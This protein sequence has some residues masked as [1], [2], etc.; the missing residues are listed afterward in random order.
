MIIFRFGL[1]D[2]TFILSLSITIVFSVFH[3]I[4]TIFQ[5]IFINQNEF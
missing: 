3:I 1:D 2:K 4:Q 5:L